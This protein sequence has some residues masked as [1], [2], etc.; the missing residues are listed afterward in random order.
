MVDDSNLFLNRVV[1]NSLLDSFNGDILNIGLLEDLRNVLGLI[2]DLIVVSHESFN[3]DLDSLSHF[4]V[5]E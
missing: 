4:V 2:F 5:L 1:L 3:W